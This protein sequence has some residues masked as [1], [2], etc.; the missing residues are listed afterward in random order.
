MELLDEFIRMK[1]IEYTALVEKEKSKAEKAMQHL[2]SDEERMK[3]QKVVEE[4]LLIEPENDEINRKATLALFISPLYESLMFFR[5]DELI[6][7]LKE[8][9]LTDAELRWFVS[10]EEINKQFDLITQKGIK[11]D[12]VFALTCIGS[13]LKSK[14]SNDI[15]FWVSGIHMDGKTPVNFLAKSVILIHDRKKDSKTNPKTVNNPLDSLLS[16]T[17]EEFDQFIQGQDK[18]NISFIKITKEIS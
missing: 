6:A 11:I 4:T 9:Q 1:D 18:F 7:K 3:A 12:K 10:I 15:S 2:L 16:E 8:F 14:F 13:Y 5:N 17:M